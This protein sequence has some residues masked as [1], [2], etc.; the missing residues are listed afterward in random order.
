MSSNNYSELLKA[1]AALFAI[2]ATR[3]YANEVANRLWPEFSK[4]YNISGFINTAAAVAAV[5]PTVQLIDVAVRSFGFRLSGDIAE[6]DLVVTSANNDAFTKLPE[7][8]IE[9]YLL[10]LEAVF[11]N[12]GGDLVSMEYAQVTAGSIKIRAALRVAKQFTIKAGKVVGN[13]VMTAASAA[14]LIGFLQSG[15]VTVILENVP[16]TY[17]ILVSYAGRT[18][19]S[20]KELL[21]FMNGEMQ[22]MYREFANE[23]DLD[24]DP[25]NDDT[26]QGELTQEQ[27]EEVAHLVERQIIVITEIYYKDRDVDSVA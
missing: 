11:A 22:E 21:D 10:F 2:E 23:Q 27:Q 25:S 6:I 18:W 26:Q 24:L 14:S 9:E 5:N 1:F 3:R 4:K 16:A 12:I 7:Y 15:D 17:N 8:E 19:N 20:L 13:A